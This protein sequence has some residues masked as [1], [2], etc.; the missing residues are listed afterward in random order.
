MNGE[1]SDNIALDMVDALT[2]KDSELASLTEQMKAMNAEMEKNK[3]TTLVTE[4]LQQGV[5]KGVGRLG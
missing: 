4:E 2:T 1:T 3:N 5:L